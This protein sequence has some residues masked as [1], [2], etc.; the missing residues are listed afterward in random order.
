MK[1]EERPL[2]YWGQVDVI[3]PTQLRV[4]G[5]HLGD[6]ERRLRLAVLEDAVRRVLRH[7]NATL[8]HERAAYQTEM[9]WF[10]GDDRS[11]PFSFESLC[12]A[13]NIDP[14]FVRRCLRQWRE[15]TEAR[16]PRS[17]QRVVARRALSPS[18]RS[19]SLDARSHRRATRR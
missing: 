2:N 11:E 1:S 3:L 15:D 14:E 16:V 8:P 5:Q 17:R 6:P 12:D 4:P 10:A 19:H 18:P 7:M 9:E 13:L